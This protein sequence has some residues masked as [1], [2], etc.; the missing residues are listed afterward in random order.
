MI[1][2]FLPSPAR[3]K[4]ELYQALAMGLSCASSCFIGNLFV[5]LPLSIDGESPSIIPC[6]SYGSG[7]GEKRSKQN[8]TEK[9][10]ENFSERCHCHTAQ[11]RA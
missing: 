2:A 11:V 9:T 4:L 7:H 5:P 6:S 3:A 1:Y 10:E 8:R